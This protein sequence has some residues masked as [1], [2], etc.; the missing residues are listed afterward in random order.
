[1]DYNET[2]GSA[3]NFILGLLLAQP[4]KSGPLFKRIYDKEVI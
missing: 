3:K 1:M 2:K 4:G